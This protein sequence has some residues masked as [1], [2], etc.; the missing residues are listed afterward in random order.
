MT[1]RAP[2]RLPSQPGEITIDILKHCS[3]ISIYIH[4]II[5]TCPGFWKVRCAPRWIVL[6]LELEI[7]TRYESWHRVEAF[8]GGVAQHKCDQDPMKRGSTTCRSN[9]GIKIPGWDSGYYCVLRFKSVTTSRTASNGPH[10][11]SH[12]KTRVDYSGDF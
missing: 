10:M 2:H 6:Y 11:L 4:L 3:K 7:S 9:D 8:G 1:C 12:G 5:C